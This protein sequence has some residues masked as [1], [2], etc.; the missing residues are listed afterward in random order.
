MKVLNKKGLS[1]FASQVRDRFDT[2]GR[3]EVQTE[4]R[5]TNYHRNH[6]SGILKTIYAAQHNVDAYVLLCEATESVPGMTHRAPFQ[7][8][9]GT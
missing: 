7:G 4:A 9:P 8:K 3:R 2:T 6:W 5:R 1:A